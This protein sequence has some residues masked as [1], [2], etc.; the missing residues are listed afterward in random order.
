MNSVEQLFKEALQ[1]HQNNQ[2]TTASDLYKKVLEL[3]PHNANAMHLLGLLAAQTN[4][5]LNSIII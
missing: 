2:L 3:D 5:Y 4:D 1:Q